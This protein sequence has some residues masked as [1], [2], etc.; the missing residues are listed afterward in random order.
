MEIQVELKIPADFKI[1]L[2]STFLVELSR[3]LE[4]ELSYTEFLELSNCSLHI[5]AFKITNRYN[6][7]SRVTGTC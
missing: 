2:S 1:E 5:H 4:V 6:R 7:G 3:Q